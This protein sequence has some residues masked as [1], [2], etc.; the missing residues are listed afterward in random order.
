MPT[1][2][3]RFERFMGDNTCKGQGPRSKQ[4]QAAT[5][6]NSNCGGQDC[7]PHT[8]LVCV[9]GDYAD[10]SVRGFADFMLKLDRG[11]VN[12]KFLS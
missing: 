8:V 7:P 4:Q 12:C 1:R 9:V 2:L 10:T 11:V 6:T 5:K 3:K